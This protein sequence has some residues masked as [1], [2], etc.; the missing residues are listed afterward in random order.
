M[1]NRRV[2]RGLRI[3]HSLGSYEVR[4][5]S[6]TEAVNSLPKNS[7]VVSDENVWSHWGKEFGNIEPFLI[8]PGE[9]SKSISVLHSVLNWLAM[10]GADRQSTVVALGGGVVGDLA[11]FAA[12]AYMRGIAVVQIPTSLMAL[13]DSSIGGKCGVNIE[14]GK[15]LVGAFHAPIA[16]HQCLDTLKTLPTTEF[17]SGT[18]EIWKYGAIADEPL[19]S[20]LLR[21]P[22]VPGD[23][24]LPRIVEKCVRIKA[25]I[26]EADEFETSGERATLNFGHTVGHALEKLSGYELSHGQAVSIGMVAEAQIGESMG[27]TQPGF[28][29]QLRGGLEKQGLP[30]ALPAMD[31]SALV[32]AMKSDKKARGGH[33]SFALVT[34][35]GQS[36]L[37]A[38]VSDQA[39]T[40]TLTA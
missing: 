26:V 1:R 24:R 23:E 6:V 14:A 34:K 21:D 18:A 15:N 16:V 9:E 38:N 3:S 22:V 7:L 12:A 33:L 8:C 31:A 11:G 17:V 2:E 13:V 32:A 25:R 5:I 20:E 37:V 27:V 19:L 30:P 4:S 29:D 28:A 10:V 39:V 35:P 36:K 40:S